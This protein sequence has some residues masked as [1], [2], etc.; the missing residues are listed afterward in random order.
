MAMDAIRPVYTTNA[1]PPRR[2]ARQEVGAETFD[3]VMQATEQDPTDSRTRQNKGQSGGVDNEAG[4]P[5]HEE[6]GEGH[7][8]ERI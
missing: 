2:G 3:H 6:A 5:P 1:R 8:D 4:R 7:I